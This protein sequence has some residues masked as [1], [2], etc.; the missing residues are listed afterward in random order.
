MAQSQN[1]VISPNLQILQ[2]LLYSLGFWQTVLSIAGC[3]PER[4]SGSIL[5]LNS[6]SPA[7]AP[8]RSPAANGRICRSQTLHV[9]PTFAYSAMLEG[10]GQCIC[11]YV[12]G[13]G[14]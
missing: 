3:A 9:E 6:L 10:L 4:L 8:Q 11:P 5:L 14:M 12:D 1:H 13:L 7:E 2:A